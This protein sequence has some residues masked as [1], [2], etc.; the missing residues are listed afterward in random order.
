MDQYLL[1]PFLVGWTSIYQLFW[2][3]LGTR[4]LTHPHIFHISHLF[5]QPESPVRAEPWRPPPLE[6]WRWC[7]SG[8]PLGCWP[9]NAPGTSKRVAIQPLVDPVDGCEILHQLIGGKH[10][11]IYRVSTIRLVVQ[12]FAG[13]STGNCPVSKTLWVWNNLQPSLPGSQIISST[14]WY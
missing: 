13:P 12:D 6:M 9:W 1:I 4:V 14:Y 7:S 11:I 3:S 2:C 10:P 5:L 8:P